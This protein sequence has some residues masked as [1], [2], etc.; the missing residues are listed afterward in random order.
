MSITGHRFLSALSAIQIILGDRKLV[1]QW[2][3]GLMFALV[4]YM[5]AYRL[6]ACSAADG[7]LMAY[8]WK[9][10]RGYTI[11]PCKEA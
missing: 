8:V 4:E 9:T 7:G 2:G 11:L 10:G 5:I 3:G 6:G 1:Y